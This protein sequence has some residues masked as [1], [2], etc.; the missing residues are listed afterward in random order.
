MIR[1]E[2]WRTKKTGGTGLGLYISQQIIENHGG[3]IGVK[4]KLDQGSMFY[5]V[6]PF[7]KKSK[8]KRKVVKRKVSKSK[9]LDDIINKL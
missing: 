1:A 9:E 7:P 2:N 3:K 6:I 5:F 4:S 8:P